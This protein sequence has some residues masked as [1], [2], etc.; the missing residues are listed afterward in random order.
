[1]KCFNLGQLWIQPR[2]TIGLFE[3]QPGCWN[4]KAAR[5][6]VQTLIC[7]PC[8]PVQVLIDFGLSYNSTLPEDKGVDLYVMERAMS[9][10]HAGMEGLVGATRAAAGAQAF[11]GCNRAL[12]GAVVFA[13]L[14]QPQGHSMVPQE[15][16]VA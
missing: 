11:A 3:P 2:V 6:P 5:N 12:P 13:R 16:E 9:S 8:K 14:L 4:P 7:T 15:A 1:M 10:A